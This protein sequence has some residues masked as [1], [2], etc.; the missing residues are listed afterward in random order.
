M[1]TLL[2]WLGYAIAAQPFYSD[3]IR[4]VRSICQAWRHRMPTLDRFLAD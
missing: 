4:T 1:R 2:H 3:E